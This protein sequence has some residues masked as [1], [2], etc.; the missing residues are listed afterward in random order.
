MP[1][2]PSRARLLSRGVLAAATVVLAAT[3]LA[4]TAGAAPRPTPKD[5][6]KDSVKVLDWL[7]VKQS[8][9]RPERVRVGADWTVHAHLYTN[10]KGKPGKKIGDASAHCS[11]VDLT[12]HGYVAL[13]HR[14]LRTDGGSI[15][16]SDTIDRFPHRRHGGLS[17]VT[18]GTGTY[19][20]AEGQAE[21]TFDGD[22]ARF[23]IKLDD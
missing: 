14:V 16:L 1:R 5:T 13:C 3:A 23:L 10:R 17:A 2:T 11:A 8:D 9:S 6:P 12:R 18:G 4:P 20:E 22:V 7:A 15:S 19:V 21:V